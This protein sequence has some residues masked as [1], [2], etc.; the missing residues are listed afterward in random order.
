MSDFQELLFSGFPPHV[1]RR[2]DDARASGK[3]S[4]SAA[5]VLALLTHPIFPAAGMNKA[6]AISSMQAEWKRDRCRVYSARVIKS[7]VKELIKRH[8]VP[9]GSSRIAGSHGYF[10][11]CSDVD[12]QAAERPLRGELRSLAHRLRVINPKSTFGHELQGQ[13]GMGG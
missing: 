2:I 9:I 7:A 4:H 5:A 13:M 1:D 11:I 6:V 12:M 10:L 8:E 3:L